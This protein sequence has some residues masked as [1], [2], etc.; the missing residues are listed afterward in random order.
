MARQIRISGKQIEIGEALPE[1]VRTALEAAIAKH[2]NGG[3]DA[4]VVFSHEGSFYRADC[5][6]HLD[7]GVVL[8]TEGE[9]G[10]VHKAFDL[11]LDHMEKRIRR[12]TRRLKEHPGK[13][14][15]KSVN[16]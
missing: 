1:H 3:A 10:D 13:R 11:A 7:S 12:Y 5:T 2:F 4:A 16:V 8:K 14:P 9:N 6:V 15:D